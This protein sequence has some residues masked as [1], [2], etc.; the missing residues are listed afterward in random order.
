MLESR[1]VKE[2]K[3]SPVQKK[4]RCTYK[5]ECG[6]D[7]AVEEGRLDNKVCYLHRGKIEAEPHLG[8]TT[9]PHL[10]QVRIQVRSTAPSDGSMFL[11][12]RLIRFGRDFQ[13]LA[14]DSLW[15][16]NNI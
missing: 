2:S 9:T 1:L 7:S 12:C 11:G 16:K 10:G 15:Y 3:D 8:E 5:A 6:T 14:I 13:I 4:G